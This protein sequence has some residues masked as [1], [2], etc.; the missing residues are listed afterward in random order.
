METFSKL[1][2][3]M[4]AL[5]KSRSTMAPCRSSRSY[6][7]GA[8]REFDRVDSSRSD[9]LRHGDQMQAGGHIAGNV[10]L[11]AEESPAAAPRFLAATLTTA[12]Y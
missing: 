12:A 6:K 7:R 10:D 2:G 4:S 9:E 11:L 3:V 5:V 8:R 1:A